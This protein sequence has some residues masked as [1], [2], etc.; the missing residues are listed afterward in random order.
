MK[1][2]LIVT[3]VD[4]EPENHTGPS[5]LV[6]EI[7]NCLRGRA[8][9]E[10]K[11]TVMST[12]ELNSDAIAA[13]DG[14]LVYPQHVLLKIPLVFW[15][16]A[17]VL[18]PDS[19]VLLFSRFIKSKNVGMVAKIRYV[20]ALTAYSLFELCILL[21]VKKVWL[22]GLLDV[23]VFALG[24]GKYSDKVSYLIHPS[25]STYTRCRRPS[26][27][28]QARRIIMFGDLQAKYVW[29]IPELI[30]AFQSGENLKVLITGRRNKWLADELRDCSMTD[31]EFVEW[32]DD[33]S[34]ICGDR[35]IHFFP[36]AA[37]AGTK[38]RV[39]G[40]L[41]FHV[42]IIASPVALENI[43][44]DPE[45]RIKLGITLWQGE[46]LDMSSVGSG[47]EAYINALMEQ[48]EIGFQLTLEEDLCIEDT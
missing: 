2:I 1:A 34:E 40:S 28:S 27:N 7:A 47:S 23:R 46:A 32:V 6:W 10:F 25:N 17:T 31:V 37:G 15:P 41:Q 24:F 13:S 35:D 3:D 48:R 9:K 26:E 44:E 18:G 29:Y 22:V 20:F 45:T 30:N 33:F 12:R 4:P 11:C 16:K 43:A 36:L 8:K 5:S 14:L 21:L 19:C 39:L 38:N 42:P